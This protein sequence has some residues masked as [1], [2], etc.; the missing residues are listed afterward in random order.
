[1]DALVRTAPFISGVPVMLVSLTSLSSLSLLSS[2]LDSS[3][4][5]S[6]CL[7]LWF[8]IPFSYYFIPVI[9]PVSSCLLLSKT[10]HLDT[11]EVSIHQ[12]AKLLL[13][14]HASH[15]SRLSLWVCMQTYFSLVICQGH[16][17][18][19][20]I[21]SYLISYYD[22]G[23]MPDKYVVWDIY[24]LRPEELCWNSIANDNK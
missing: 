18:D 4:D 1:M 20:S 3:T 12:A 19:C 13:K 6:I 15:Q 8:C 24:T 23:F 16:S 7:S 5:S 22:S 11:S 14:S 21:L 2:V 9:F 10:L 17:E